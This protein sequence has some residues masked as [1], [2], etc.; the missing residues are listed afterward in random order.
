MRGAGALMLAALALAGCGSGEKGE[1]RQQQEQARASQVETLSGWERAFTPD[2]AVQAANQFGFRAKPYAAAQD[3]Y[4]TEGGPIALSDPSAKQPNQARFAG[5]GAAANQ[6]DTL[7]FDL[8]LGDTANAANARTR[9][10]DLI[11]DYLFQSKIDGGPIHAAIAKG[12]QA[13]GDLAGIRYAIAAA[14]KDGAQHLSVTF[15]RT[16]ASAPANS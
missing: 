1:T 9:F 8:S 4:R 14:P 7:S 5:T 3:Q 11:R 16:G 2:L 12:E 10:A 13:A 6:V 15:H